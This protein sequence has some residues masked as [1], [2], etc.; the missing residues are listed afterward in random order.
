MKKYLLSLF[1]SLIATVALAQQGLPSY[2]YTH[3]T[4]ATTTVIKGN[5]STGAA[6]SGVLHTLCL[7][8]PNAGSTVTI[9]DNT[10]G[11]GNV[12]AIITASTTSIGC[13]IFDTK[14]ITGLTIVTA[15]GSQDITVSW[16]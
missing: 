3:I 2:Q 6:A 15:A 14:F 1:F 5:A 16:Q 4:T 10:A 8:N 12:I 13:F 9:Y 7:N 11:S